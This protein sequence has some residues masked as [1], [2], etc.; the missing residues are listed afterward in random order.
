[1]IATLTLTQIIFQSTGGNDMKL[2]LLIKRVFDVVVSLTVLIILFPIML[3]L[4]LLICLKLGWP[5]FFAHERPGL[6]GRPFKMIKFRS[7]LNTRDNMGNLLLDAERLTTFGKALRS[8][9]LDELP[10]LFCVLKG[11]MSLVGPRPL[12]MQYLL[13]YNER[14]KKRHIMRPGISGWAQVNGRNALTWDEKFEFDVWYVENWS[15]LLDLKILIMT[16]WKVFKREGI[17]QKEN[18]SSDMWVGN[19]IT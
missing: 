10:E 7:M 3:F 9:S 19:N 18:L 5:I 14:Q 17:N 1:M 4:G 13:L 11:E 6:H 16:V 12:H 15:L 2:Q 8:L